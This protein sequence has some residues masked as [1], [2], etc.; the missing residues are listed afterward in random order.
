[1]KTLIVTANT[2]K[3][4]IKSCIRQFFGVNYKEFKCSKKHSA[5]EIND[6]TSFSKFIQ[7]R[8]GEWIIITEVKVKNAGLSY[9][10][11]LTGI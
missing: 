2:Q 11:K 10:V 4:I 3:P 8:F 7:E 6:F 9:L 5:F 1:M